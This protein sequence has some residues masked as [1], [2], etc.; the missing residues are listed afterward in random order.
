MLEEVPDPVW[1]TSI[2]N[3]SSCSP[4]ATSS[5]A[6]AIRSAIAGSSWPSS[7][8]VRAAAALIR[9]SQWI[10]G[11]G[12]G[13]PEIWKFSTAFV[14]SPPQSWSVVFASILSEAT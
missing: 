6:P 10:T 1:K 7:A 14:V 13:W 4:F 5:P 12:I 11:P 8:L 3:C 9:P 2:G